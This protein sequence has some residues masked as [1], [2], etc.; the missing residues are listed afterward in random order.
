M[1]DLTRRLALAACLLPMTLAVGQ[2]AASSAA[3]PPDAPA[4]PQ[5]RKAPR[6][7]SSARVSRYAN[8]ET[9]AQRQR[10][11][12]ARLKRECRGRPNAGACLGYTR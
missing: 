8:G 5:D 1:P 3:P 7:R 4:T 9:E 6:R 10:R 2:A 11:E 12:E